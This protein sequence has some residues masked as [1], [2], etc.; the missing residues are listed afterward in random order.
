[1]DVV[2]FNNIREKLQNNQFE[3]SW[4]AEK[5]KQQ[6]KITYFEIDEAFKTLEV[7]EDYP[8]DPRGNSCLTLGF[9]Y[10]HKALHF[11]LGNLEDEKILIITIYRPKPEE[12]IDFARRQR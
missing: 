9:T 6:D 1:M 3:L 4:H 12:W 5:E 2:K 10:E 7:I 8:D 11:V